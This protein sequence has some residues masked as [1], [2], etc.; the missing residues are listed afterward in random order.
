MN[1][2]VYPPGIAEWNNLRIRCALGTGGISKKQNEG[3]GITPAGIF[4]LRQAFFRSDRTNRPETILPISALTRSDGWSDDP[5][6]PRYNRQ[7]SIPT[8]N[9]HETLWRADGVYDLIAVIGY[10]D[11]PVIPGAGS[12]IFLHVAKLGYAPTEGCVAFALSDL[13]RILNEWEET[14]VLDIRAET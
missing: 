2:V 12:A 6:D 7:I 13:S 11:R 14:S 8:K 10:N 1:L 9:N 5:E 3:D 4:P